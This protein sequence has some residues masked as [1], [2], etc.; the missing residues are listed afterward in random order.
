MHDGFAQVVPVGQGIPWLGFVV[1]PNHRR[2]KGRRVRFAARR[3]GQRFEDWRAGRISFGE[4]DASV[5]GWINHVRF[6]DTWALR[7]KLLGDFVWG[8]EAYP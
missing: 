7:E 1:F 5:Q 8:P 4:F 3:L 6:A 2:L